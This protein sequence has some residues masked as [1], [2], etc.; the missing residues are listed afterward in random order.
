[1][2]T[3]IGG[4]AVRRDGSNSATGKNMKRNSIAL[5]AVM[6]MSIGGVVFAMRQGSVE[7]TK[8]LTQLQ[9]DDW[10]Q[11][12]A[13]LD[14]LIA[15]S[16][17]RVA[18]EV[19]A[20]LI[21]LLVRENQL[22]EATLRASKGVEGVSVKYGEGYSE[23]YARLLSAIEKAVDYDDERTLVVL[24]H[25]SYN[26]DSPFAMKLAGLGDVV[27]PLLLERTSSDIAPHR[28]TA[29]AVLG[30]I[31]KRDKDRTRSLP[32]SVRQQIEQALMRGAVDEDVG[33]RMLAVRSLGKAGGKDALQLLEG[34]AESDPA[35]VP[36]RIAGTSTYPVRDEALKAMKLINR[37]GKRNPH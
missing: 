7:Q 20:A 13:S 31:M 4:E 15:N 14:K 19:N 28:G 36:G 2:F 27:V 10:R 34:I 25:S 22:I 30:E 23:Y 37:Q 6:A 33:V 8:L 29:L 17:T 26:P 16:D 11:R 5:L 32:P 35:T 12:A 18:R 21:D 3:L 1:M 24:I 9:S